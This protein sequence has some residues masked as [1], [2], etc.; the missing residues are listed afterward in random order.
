MELGRRDVIELAIGSAVAVGAG[1]ALAASGGQHVYSIDP[2]EISALANAGLHQEG[3]TCDVIN[4]KA[5]VTEVNGTPST[6][7]F[8]LPGINSIVPV[9]KSLRQDTNEVLLTTSPQLNKDHRNLGALDL[10]IACYVASEPFGLEDHWRSCKKCYGVFRGEQSDRPCSSSA[11][12][13]HDPEGDITLIV[14]GSEASGETGW[15]HCIKCDMLVYFG[16]GVH[17]PCVRGGIHDLSEQSY[18]MPKAA[19]PATFSSENPYL[20]ENWYNRCTKCQGLFRFWASGTFP[21][22]T[23]CPGGGGGHKTSGSAIYVTPAISRLYDYDR[24]WN[25]TPIYALFGPNTQDNVLTTDAAEQQRAIAGGYHDRG[26][27]G[28]GIAWKKTVIPPPV[29]QGEVDGKNYLTLGSSVPL[30]RFYIDFVPDPD[31][32]GFFAK[33]WKGLEDAGKIVGEIILVA[34]PVIAYVIISSLGG[35]K[36]R[37]GCYDSLDN[38]RTVAYG[39]DDPSG[40]GT[41]T[42]YRE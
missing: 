3:L 29:T 13:K 22:A 34:L 11:G 7:T 4:V 6:I 8:E 30:F 35:G 21:V 25:W 24:A 18:T 31:P 2:D 38:R 27:M 36:P 32:P 10:G 16:K 9:F 19:P 15:F 5:R 14:N 41:G 40:P 17:G 23:R 28:Y 39:E 33:L 12:G 20:T 42:C 1:D 37:W 26:I